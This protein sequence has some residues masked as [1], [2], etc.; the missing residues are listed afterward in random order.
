METIIIVVLVAIGLVF[1]MFKGVV[2]TFRR[3]PIVAVLLIL[4]LFPVWLIW[5]FVEM[6]TNPVDHRA[7]D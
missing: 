5:A 2:K 3:Q 1:L 4:F 7:A 6:F